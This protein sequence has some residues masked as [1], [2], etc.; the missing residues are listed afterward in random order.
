MKTLK[1]D[2]LSAIYEAFDPKIWHP[3]C[4]ITHGLHGLLWGE[5]NLYK[6]EFWGRKLAKAL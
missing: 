5:F 6:I 3:R 1:A 4:L 2:K